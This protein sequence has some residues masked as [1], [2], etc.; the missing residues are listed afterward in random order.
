MKQSLLL[1]AALMAMPASAQDDFSLWTEMTVQK[2][3]GKKFSVDAAFEFRAEDKVSQPARWAVSAGAT[4]KPAKFLSVSAGYVFLHD[5]SFQEAEVDYKNDDN[6]QPTTEFNGY[7]VDHGYWR[8]KHRATFDVT[9]KLPLGRFTLSLRERYQFTHLLEAN[10]LRDKYRKPVPEEMLPGWTGDRYEYAGQTFSK[11][12]QADKVKS[13]KNRHYLRSRLG[14]EYNIRHCDWTPYVSYELSNNLAE[15][16]HLDKKR[17][18]VGVEWKVTKQHRLDFAYVYE[19]GADDDA[20]SNN[21]A[22]SLSYKFKF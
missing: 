5:Y 9:G 13:A 3:L 12:E 17:L 7:N 15:S 14:V 20:R 2:D 18:T 4:Y 21:H 19:N 8:N 1:A 16:L 10:T 6:G 22:L 11:F